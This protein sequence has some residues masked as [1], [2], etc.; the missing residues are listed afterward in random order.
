MRMRVFWVMAAC[1]LAARA[2]TAG[3]KVAVINI[4]DAIVRT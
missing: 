4:Q 3:T 2:Q 1:T